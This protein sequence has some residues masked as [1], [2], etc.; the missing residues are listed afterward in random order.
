MS[1][2]RLS[3]RLIQRVDLLPASPVLVHP[4]AVQPEC[5]PQGSSAAA[6]M[7]RPHPARRAA[8]CAEGV[9][10]PS[11][12]VVSR[13]LAASQLSKSAQLFEQWQAI[14]HSNYVPC[15]GIRPRQPPGMLGAA[16]PLMMFEAVN[17]SQSVVRLPCLLRSCAALVCK[18]ARMM[19]LRSS[20]LVC[21]RSQADIV[22]PSTPGRPARV[23]VVTV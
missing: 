20:E 1:F 2:L 16:V 6:Q 14:R 5:Q 9:L 10:G 13:C 8:W 21:H 17:P 15:D 12:P 22:V 19:N 11:L 23:P 4:D 3:G 7:S 18:I